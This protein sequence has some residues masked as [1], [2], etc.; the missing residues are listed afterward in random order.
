MPLG[1]I[2]VSLKPSLSNLLVVNPLNV[3][4]IYRY[5]ENFT[6]PHAEH[7]YIYICTAATTNNCSLKS[8]YLSFLL[9]SY[10]LYK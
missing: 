10:L 1:V 3:V 6:T 2:E 5:A 4:H 9:K 8:F 7:I